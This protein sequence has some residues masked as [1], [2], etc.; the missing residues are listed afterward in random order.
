MAET[1][2]IH[3]PQCGTPFNVEIAK[4]GRLRT[5]GCTYAKRLGH[6]DVTDDEIIAAV[7]RDHPTLRGIRFEPA[8]KALKDR[9]Q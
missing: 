3:C 2:S 8:P 7:E 5:L 6:G 9:W 4:D 1:H